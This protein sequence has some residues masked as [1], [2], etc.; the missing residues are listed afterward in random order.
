MYRLIVP[1]SVVGV[2]GQPHSVLADNSSARLQLS[3]VHLSP[4]KRES[5][6]VIQAGSY[7]ILPIDNTERIN[8]YVEEMMR[9]PVSVELRL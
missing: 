7:L 3:F 9:C 8:D 1:G 2:S 4:T 6:I 5:F